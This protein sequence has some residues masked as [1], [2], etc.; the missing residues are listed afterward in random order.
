MHEIESQ[1]NVPNEQTSILLH[2]NVSYSG[3]NDN[4]VDLKKGVTFHGMGN[5]NEAISCDS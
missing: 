5:S 1:K 4:A 3:N 2:K